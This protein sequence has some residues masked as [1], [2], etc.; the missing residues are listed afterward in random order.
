MLLTKHVRT[1]FHV[2]AEENQIICDEAL[3][4]MC[5]CLKKITIQS[6]FTENNELQTKG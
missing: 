4:I 1:V 3:F 6:C 5:Q 2:Q